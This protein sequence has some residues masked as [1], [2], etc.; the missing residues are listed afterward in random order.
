MKINSGKFDNLDVKVNNDVFN[1]QIGNED[2]YSAIS[3]DVF[4]E[5]QESIEYASNN[6][7]IRVVV[8]EGKGENFSSGGNIKN[9][10]N[11]LEN[12]IEA[13]SNIILNKDSHLRTILHCPKPII[14]KVD[15]YATGAG[16]TLATICDF[17]IATHDAKIGDPHVG[18]GF[19]APDTPAFW[20]LLIGFN[21]TKELILTGDLVDGKQA[22]E[23]GLVNY[24]VPKED[25]DSK[26]E[27][28]VNELASGPQHAIYYSKLMTNK[29]LQWSF[30]YIADEALAHEAMTALLPDHKSA[31]DAFVE[32]EPINFPSG[33]GN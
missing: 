32:D 16:A 25:L 21:K 2:D 31:V 10:Q 15:G 14:S 11:R 33:R 23:I 30:L 29:W 1:I 17:T 28:I 8:M 18:I 3:Q 26:V 13:W 24:S 4:G 22:E 27:E 20:P 5:I 9:M 6:D 12:G 19:S 7:N